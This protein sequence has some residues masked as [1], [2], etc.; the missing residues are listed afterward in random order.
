MK[1][2]L[3]LA[4]ALTMVITLAVPIMA[5]PSGFIAGKVV[6][7]NK[8]AYDSFKGKEITANNSSVA[9]DK[10]SFIADNKTL[11]AWYINVT[12]SIRGELE[13]AYKIG[14]QYYIVT[15]DIN[16]AGK[17][18][19]ADSRGSDGASMA[20]I[21]EFKGAGKKEPVTTISIIYQPFSNSPHS[22]PDDEFIALVNELEA[23]GITP[24]RLSNGWEQYDHWVD[25]DLYADEKVEFEVPTYYEFVYKGVRYAVELD[26]VQ[27]D[28]FNPVTGDGR[29]YWEGEIIRVYTSIVDDIT[30][31]INVGAS[32][33]VGKINGYDAY[34][35]YYAYVHTALIKLGPVASPPVSSISII[36]QPF[37]NSPHS[38]PDDEFIALVNELEAEGITPL[39]L[40]NGWTQY[41]HW[42]DYDL[43]ADEKVEFEVPTYYE[44]EYN[45]VRYAVELDVVQL[46]IHNPVTN[47]LGLYYDGEIN[48]DYTS[49]VDNI[50]RNIC[51]GASFT[52]EKVDGYDAY[53]I[54]YA[55]VSSAIIKLGPVA[56]PPVTS[57]GII[58]QGFSNS[59]HSMPDDEFIALVDELNAEGITP[60][61]LT[62]GW[63]Q[64]DHWIDYD[65]RAGET[66][67]FEVP[68]YYEFEYK[69][70]RYAVELDVVQ[71]EIFNPV[72][73]I[74]EIF[75]DGE[76]NKDYT[77]VVD[78]ISRNI[79]VGASFTVEKVD[80][81][82]EYYIYSA[83]V[84]TV[85]IKL[86][87]VAP[88]PQPSPNVTVMFW[89]KNT[90][91]WPEDFLNSKI[92]GFIPGGTEL[93]AVQGVETLM[94]INDDF[95][96]RTVWTVGLD[97]PVGT[98]IENIGVVF[99]DDANLWYVG[100]HPCSVMRALMSIDGCSPYDIQFNYEGFNL[101]I[102]A[103]FTYTIDIMLAV[104]APFYLP[105]GP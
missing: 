21:G 59:P 88:P 61:R 11:N 38:M 25:Y 84:H 100:E 92:S 73:S 101:T 23:E 39:R 65:L 42:V 53:Y 32:F 105:P 63:E 64:Y 90:Y 15:F 86:E 74:A 43:Y 33:T 57:I 82:D 71:L 9:F 85:L 52:V 58:Y 79:C 49:I 31:N 78:G 22:M 5:A 29:L 62:N 35:T 102:E 98:F 28:I 80:G 14:S 69:G 12:D 104:N 3:S 97:I 81:S 67:E 34:Y 30:R 96:P 60:L 103:G 75:Y 17:Y 26:V 19:I 56:S 68:T 72:T 24:L 7:I 41:D 20:K 1:K 66:V 10:F 93:L 77:S 2:F 40:S 46:E 44:I 83:Y 89:Y 94:K 91:G 37:S 51:V 16:G 18:F 55:Y 4:L 48:K 76:I 99:D 70:V 6:A 47:S 95:Y 50:S 87:P 13:V 54:Y 27:L 45:G 36:Y 8:N